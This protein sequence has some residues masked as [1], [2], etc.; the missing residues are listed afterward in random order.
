MN[1]LARW[2]AQITIAAALAG[3]PGLA[4]ESVQDDNVAP[5]DLSAQGFY[6]PNLFNPACAD[7]NQNAPAPPQNAPATPR[8]DPAVPAAPDKKQEEEPPGG[9][10]VFG[11]LPNY[12]TASSCDEGEAISAG[13]KLHIAVKDS[14]DYPLILLSAAYA[15]FDQL[16]DDEPS[17]GQGVK[18]YAH[19]LVTNYADQAI[20]NMMT[21]GFLPVVFH[22]DP[23]YFRRGPQYR[24]WYRAW[25][26]LTRVIVTDS[27]DGRKEFNYSEWIGNA[28]A[29]ALSNIWEPDDRTAS[30]NT[31]KL[32]E[33]VGTDAFSQV[34]KEFWP[35]LKHKLFHRG[36]P[37]EGCGH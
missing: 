3:I 6:N 36:N 20:G 16:T 11:V 28:S 19:R 5:H 23:R 37:D 17:F 1:S 7:P 9:K 31:V 8:S 32:L 18:G 22:Q 34:L 27:D 15:G 33:Y 10:R 35:D 25:Y 24:R 13:H 30:A 12:R 4:Q 14:F 21:E 2:G 29:A 26:A